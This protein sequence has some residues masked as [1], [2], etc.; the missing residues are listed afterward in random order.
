MYIQWVDANFQLHQLKKRITTWIFVARFRLFSW[1][2]ATLR[3]RLVGY[4][5]EVSESES[6]PSATCQGT[7]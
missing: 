7:L 4:V 3:T 1:D 5:R 2:S 6:V